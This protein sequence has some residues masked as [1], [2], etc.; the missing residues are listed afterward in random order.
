MKHEDAISMLVSEHREVNAKFEEFFALGDD[1][2]T[3]KKE[4]ADEICQALTIHTQIEEEL[5][6]PAVRDEID[7]DGL[8]DEALVEHAGAK[9]LIAEI[10]AM[11]PGDDLYDAKVKVLSEQIAHH[12]REEES[13]M[14]PKVRET[15]LDLV[16]LGAEMAK[17]KQ[18]LQSAEA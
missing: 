18:E 5:F 11:V 2:K 1:D 8:M 7:D 12:V 4:L 14:F 6:Y 10:S 9:T 17:C 13:D 3:A 16:A 15:G